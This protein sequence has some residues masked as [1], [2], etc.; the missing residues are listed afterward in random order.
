MTASIVT[1]TLVGLA[2]SALPLL[3]AVVASILLSGQITRERGE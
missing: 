3:A 1:I 2:I